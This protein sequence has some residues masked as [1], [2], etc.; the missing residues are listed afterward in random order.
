MVPHVPVLI[1]GGGP[2][3]L[4]AALFLARQGIRPLLVERR[5]RTSPMPRATHVTRRSMELFREA[6]IEPEIARAGFEV[7][8]AADPRV[9]SDPH[10][11][12]PRLVVAVDSIAA[13]V[14]NAEILETGEEELA[15]PGPCP[16]YWCGQD[17]L[18][19]ILRAAAT[20]AGA[21]VRFGHELV[22]LDPGRT[23]VTAR[24]RCGET[25][26]TR[27]VRARYLVAA[28]GAGG[29]TADRVG[30]PFTGLGTIAHRMT[31]LFRANLDH[32]VRGRRFFMS[33]IENPAFSGAIMQLNDRD[34]W[35]AAIGYGPTTGR[36]RADFTP[37]HCLALIRAAIGDDAVGVELD[38]VFR[39][40]ARHRVARTYRSGPVFLAGDAAH[41][42]PP[43]GGFG[44]NVGFQDAHNLAW[45]I[46][47]VCRGWAGED[48]LDSYDPE[49][50]PVGSATA[51]QSLLLDGVPAERLGGA[52]PCD[53][54]TLIMGYRYDSPAVLGARPG[55]PFPPV[56]DLS[57]SPGTRMPHVRIGPVS[58]LDLV[59]RRFT[60]FSGDP[61][62]HQAADRVRTRSGV[63]V[64]GHLLDVGGVALVRP[65]GFVAWRHTGAVPDD[66]DKARLLSWVLGRIVRPARTY[67]ESSAP[68]S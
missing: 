51:E 19:P 46:A 42:H 6:G 27:T 3:G 50:R 15:V 64:R 5:G 9:L 29:R 39:W 16:P 34:R 8:T 45:K 20:R 22:G 14:R 58:T 66:A 18:E 23:G 25:G 52:T 26:S 11:T 65:D 49:R 68:A 61:G 44:S 35:A 40:E 53:P 2:V 47:A 7:V 28:D 37:Q 12:L 36:T 10:R 1:V 56:F 55:G 67:R 57:W 48:L 43:S 4:A 38:G 41:L 54:R 62:W 30:I 63:P 24:I 60:V 59:G 21:D 32:L 17:R 31:I 33:M 13:G